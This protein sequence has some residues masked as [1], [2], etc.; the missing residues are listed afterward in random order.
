[1]SER[2]YLDRLNVAVVRVNDEKA[3]AT[4]QNSSELGPSLRVFEE[5]SPRNK[6]KIEIIRKVIKAPDISSK[7]RPV[8]GVGVHAENLRSK[9]LFKFSEKFAITTPKV[10]DGGKGLDS[11]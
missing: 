8:F 5:A 11:E 9:L 7:M 1:M 10:Y 3:A 2:T 4:L 6:S